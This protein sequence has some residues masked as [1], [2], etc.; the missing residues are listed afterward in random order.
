MLGGLARTLDYIPENDPQ[1]PFYVRQ[2]REMSAR[3]AG[4][5][6]KDG[7]FRHGEG[8]RPLLADQAWA[9]RAL[10]GIDDAAAR[11]AIVA[12]QQKWTAPSGALYD[13]DALD[14]GRLRDREQPLVDNAVFAR[15]AKSRKIL[16]AFSGSYLSYGIEAAT[17]A[18]AIR[19]L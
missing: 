13:G 18:L 5:Q 12:A 1:K 4:L 17:W 11:R 3:I 19:N 8:L 10:T 2:L 7:L 6:G 16:E 9:A 14:E 15:V